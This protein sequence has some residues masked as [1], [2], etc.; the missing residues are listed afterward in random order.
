MQLFFKKKTDLRFQEISFHCLKCT[1]HHF[2]CVS[3]SSS[4]NWR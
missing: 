2:I 4:Q 3:F 1:F